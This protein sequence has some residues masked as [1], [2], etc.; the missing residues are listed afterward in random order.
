MKYVWL[1]L[2]K[3]AAGTHPRALWRALPIRTKNFDEAWKRFKEIHTLI[4][5]ENV[6]VF[7][8]VHSVEIAAVRGKS[9]IA[10]VEKGEM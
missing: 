2:I 1:A 7:E 10:R 6:L 9:W 3:N 4:N 8:R 5:P